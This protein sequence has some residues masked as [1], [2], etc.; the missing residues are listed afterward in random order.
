MSRLSFI[1]PL[2]DYFKNMLIKSWVEEFKSQ[3]S[4]FFI[5]LYSNRTN[6]VC[7]FCLVNIRTFS[8]WCATYIL[9]GINYSTISIMHTLLNQMYFIWV[10][11]FLFFSFL[12]R[13]AGSLYFIH[14]YEC[15]SHFPTTVTDYCTCIPPYHTVKCTTATRGNP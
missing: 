4:M 1:F 12:A 15:E 10:K 8:K 6:R 11:I 5:T 14:I 2:F 9:A 7:E 13:R 3:I